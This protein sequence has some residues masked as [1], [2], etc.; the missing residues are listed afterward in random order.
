MAP[1]ALSLLGPQ[2]DRQ[3][4]FGFG[5]S[6]NHRAL[7]D[8]RHIATYVNSIDTFLAKDFYV[9][10]TAPSHLGSL[11]TDEARARGL[12]HQIV[13]HHVSGQRSSGASRRRIF[14][15]AML[16]GEHA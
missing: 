9:Q 7:G 4:L 13:P 8:R 3:V 14:N 10:Q 6:E 15:D 12:R 1:I 16:G 2:F 11:L 5:F